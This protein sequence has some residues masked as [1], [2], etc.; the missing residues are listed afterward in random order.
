MTKAL[1][2]IKQLI[3]LGEKATAGRVVPNDTNPYNE[4]SFIDLLTSACCCGDGRF[5]EEHDCDFFAFA[6]NTRQAL[7]DF[8]AEYERMRLSLRAIER[9]AN[10]DGIF[11]TE[12]RTR[13]FHLAKQA[14][15]ETEQGE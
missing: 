6:M 11:Y 15:Q 12:L 1:E 4:D 10:D 8:V 13:V 3:A 5:E 2:K 14:L 9:M 7:A